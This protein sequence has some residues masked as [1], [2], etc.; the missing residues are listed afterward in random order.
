MEPRV[1]AAAAPSPAAEIERPAPPAA[2]APTAS[3][4]AAGPRRFCLVWLAAVLA[5][6]A[7]IGAFDALIDPYLV[8]GTPRIAGLN[9]VK[10]ATETHT[11]LAKG[12]LL[13]RLHP[14]G[15][16]IG[17][18]KVDLGLDPDSPS[19][20]DDALPAFNY[21]MPGAGLGD[22]LANLRRAVARGTVRRALILLEPRDFMAPAP[23]AATPPEPAALSDLQAFG[24]RASD[25]LL[26][27]LSLDALRAS[28]VTV[29]AQG[30]RDVAD[31]SPH[32]ATGEG[33]FRAVIAADGYDE[34]F[35]Q[36]DAYHRG[37][38]AQLIAAIRARP[39]AGLGQLDRVAEMIDLCRRHGIALDL[40]IAPAHA[41][42]LEGLDH[43]GLWPRYQA[44]KAAF[45]EL[46]AEADSDTVRLW[47]FSFYDAYATEKVPGP[48]DRGGST[49]WFWEPSHFKRALGEKILATIYRGADDY[50][51]R[52]TPDMIAAHLA[53]ETAAKAAYQAQ[54]TGS[55]ERLARAAAE[56]SR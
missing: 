30:K 29:A 3:L 33:G 43:A 45:V 55:R 31:L 12:H 14:A 41:D 54:D 46:A 10:P 2:A 19:W 9:A 27:T 37:Q 17:D 13:A 6:I 38:R 35:M 49:R 25:I 24:E 8:I 36:K 5:L 7:L 22:Q 11:R 39:G 4:T 18:S 23:R 48:S 26:A 40:A 50:G 1:S 44:V 53:R 34:L 32:G 42:Y 20:P 16:L 15:L 56:A 28:L 52:L 47:D 21:G 51:V